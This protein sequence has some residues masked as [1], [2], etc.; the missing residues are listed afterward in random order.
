M[1]HFLDELLTYQEGLEQRLEHRTAELT[2]TREQ[3][4]RAI[5]NYEEAEVSLQQREQHFTSLSDHLPDIIIR[6][7]NTLHYL[8]A[9]SAIEHVTG[10]PVQEFIG[11]TSFELGL[12]DDIYSNWQKICLKVFETGQKSSVEFDLPTSQGTRWYHARIVPEFDKDGAVFSVLSIAHDI[13]ERKKAEEGLRIYQK[14]LKNLAEQR[15]KELSQ[16]N[17]E[18][19]REIEER[20][21][22]EE[23]LRF[24]EFSVERSAIATFWLEANGSV[25]HVNKAACWLLGYSRKEFIWMSIYDFSPTFSQEMWGD[26]WQSLFYGQHIAIEA[27]YR[28]KDGKTFP[29][30]VDTN[31]F[32]YDGKAYCLS[33]ARDITERKYA[34]TEL[35][36]AKEAAEA[37]NQAKSNFLANMSHELRTPLNG[38]LGY[39]Q[40]LK[41]DKNL[42]RKQQEAIQTMHS[43][44]E[45]LLLMINDILDLSKI[46]AQKMELILTEIYLPQFLRGVIDI[47]QIR[48]KQKALPLFCDIAPD[49]PKYIRGDEKRLRQ[50]LLNLLSNA[51]KFTEK[52]SVK[53]Q[54]SRCENNPAG[55]SEPRHPQLCFLVEDSGIGVPLEKLQEIFLPFHQV[56]DLR[57]QA[58]GTGLGLAISQRLVRM[59]GGELQVQSTVGKGSLFWFDLELPEVVETIESDIRE[60]PKRIIGFKGKPRTILLVDDKESNRE[61]LKDLLLPLGFQVIEA[62]H[63]RDALDKASEY[64]PDVIFMDLLMPVMDGFEATKR[65]RQLPALKNVV[66]IAVSASAFDSTKEQSFASG[67]DDYISKPFQI[68]ELLEKLQQFLKLEWMYADEFPLHTSAMQA[69]EPPLIALPE[70]E[71]ETLFHFAMMGDVFS[72]QEY[73]EQLEAKDA[74]FAPFLARVTSL[75]KE[76]LIDEIQEFLRHYMEGD[77]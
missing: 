72:L 31:Y 50:I 51:I 8:Y 11:K 29:V 62:I 36:K 2:A 52:G 61:L 55:D 77:E 12:S 48:A 59:M 15:T 33:F 60:K 71:L 66:I 4:N 22:I 40:I 67:C 49:I 6:F 3:L 23:R 58:E 56:G 24:T 54:I 21:R 34:E 37:A 64:I 39:T 68:N 57:V 44:G 26:F 28:A 13:T 70:D 53:F 73:A 75:A 10:I 20:N 1:R 45:Y 47:A 46:E 18:L 41:H 42:T 5:K 32:E 69:E 14:Y 43:S 76:F 30:E 65:I 7:D 9:N 35:R 16:R 17:E 27:T 74:K 19:K 38:I 25:F 63:G